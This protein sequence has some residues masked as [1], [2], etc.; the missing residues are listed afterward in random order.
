[1]IIVSNN[2]YVYVVDRLDRLYNVSNV[3]LRDENKKNIAK[4]KQNKTKQNKTK[5]NKTKQI[6]AKQNKIK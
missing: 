3:R 5:Q 1:M 4:T 2:V 6:K